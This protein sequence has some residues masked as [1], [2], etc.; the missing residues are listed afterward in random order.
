MSTTHVNS[1]L[2]GGQY[3]LQWNNIAVVQN[4]LARILDVLQDQNSKS[5]NKQKLWDCS[6]F[7]FFYLLLL[8]NLNYMEH[9]KKRNALHMFCQ[10]C[11][12]SSS[13]NWLFKLE[14]ICMWVKIMPKI[15]YDTGFPFE[16]KHRKHLSLY[17][18]EYF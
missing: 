14:K 3:D 18:D 4:V 10:M 1:T 17:L 15:P 2:S 5:T 9:E 6:F 13:T 8:L 7:F 11:G 12:F 16:R